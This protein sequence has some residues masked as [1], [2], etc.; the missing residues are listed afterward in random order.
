MAFEAAIRLLCQGISVATSI[1][2]LVDLMQS[3]IASVSM[4]RTST[5]MGECKMAVNALHG[6]LELEEVEAGTKPTR[7]IDGGSIGCKTFLLVSLH[8]LSASIF[9]K[10]TYYSKLAAF[11][12]SRPRFPPVPPAPRGSKTNR[13]LKPRSGG[14]DELERAKLA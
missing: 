1:E 12:I 7:R 11:M 13:G 9:P 2:G 5:N 4:S 3:I 8:L 10:T 6:C 14:G